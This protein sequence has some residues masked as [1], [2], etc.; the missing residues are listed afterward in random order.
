[1]CQAWRVGE[2]SRNALRPP[3]QPAQP[4]L[5][6]LP[7][8]P[9]PPALPALP[10]PRHLHG[11]DDRGVCDQDRH[12]HVPARAESALRVQH[13]DQLELLRPTPLRRIALAMRMI[14]PEMRRRSQPPCD[15]PLLACTL[16][17]HPRAQPPL[18]A[19]ATLRVLR[20]RSQLAQHRLQGRVLLEHL[21]DVRHVE[22][23]PEGAR[24]LPVGAKWE[25][26]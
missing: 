13:W 17:A 12:Q 25:R 21:M 19:V 23:T 24:H 5:P 22:H 15:A 1:M 26:E 7:A 3:A 9:A 6:S 14:A 2:R 11:H 8:L 18:E 10:T 16:H 4:A 20:R